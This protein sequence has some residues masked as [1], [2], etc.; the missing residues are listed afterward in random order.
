GAAAVPPPARP[1]R[2]PRT[3]YTAAPP[4]GPPTAPG[5]RA[6]WRDGRSRRRLLLPEFA[7]QLQAAL[8]GAGGTAEPGGDLRVLV[9]LH[10][11]QGDRFQAGVAQ[12]GQQPPALL[13]HLGRE[14]RAGL[15]AQDR[16]Q[17]H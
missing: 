9:A 13:R 5:C 4:A 15:A 3:R 6:A 8:D 14:L 10:L 17:G 7:D 2:P 12:A 16:F 1:A 11:P